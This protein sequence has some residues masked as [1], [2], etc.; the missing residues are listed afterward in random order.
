VND[1]PVVAN[2]LADL[3]GDEYDGPFTVDVSSVFTDKD[4]D[5][6][7]MTGT[8]SDTTVVRVSVTGT[9]LTISE[10][11]PG[12]AEITVTATDPGALFA[13][14]RFV[15]TLVN[16]NDAPEAV[17]PVGFL[18]LKEYFE[19]V[20][21]DI[22][23]V[24]FDKDGDKMTYSAMSSNTKVLTVS[25][26]GEK[27]ILNE[28]GLGTSTITL[29][30]SDGSL[31]GDDI[32]EVSVDNVNDNPLVRKL[33]PDQ[34]QY[35]Y[36][37]S[38]VVDLH[39]VFSDPDVGDILTLSVYSSDTSVVK[40]EIVD[41]TVVIT[42][43][44]LGTSAITVTVEDEGGLSASVAFGFTVWNVNDAPVLVEAVPDFELV[45]NIGTI[46][47]GLDTL[48]RDKDRDTLTYSI[49][50]SNPDLVGVTMTDSVLTFDALDVGV[51]QVILTA[52]DTALSAVDTF[53]ITVVEEVLLLLRY[54]GRRIQNK[55]TIDVCN[56]AGAVFVEVISSVEWGVEKVSEATWLVLGI[57]QDSSLNLAFS[58]NLLE[59]PRVAE[60]LVYDE[61][62]HQFTFYLEQSDCTIDVEGYGA[63]VGM[64]M[65]PNPVEH[66]L[67]ISPAEG[68]LNGDVSLEILDGNGRLLL[69]QE[70]GAGTG[71][72][73]V[74]M[75]GYSEGMYFV[76][77]RSGE[78][79]WMEK[80]IKL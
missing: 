6:L 9:T 29:T 20:D 63:R 64:R 57:D 69:Q 15:F 39:G 72:V 37:E 22:S 34:E 79:T 14:D 18:S 53:N 10:V 7:I 55:D 33:I 23:D 35:E 11:A 16:V 45:N 38:L 68:L 78:G 70:V 40:A 50:V 66:V 27:L 30:A 74:D 5:P 58:Q 26:E 36:F 42:E 41:T 80:V 31:S 12:S 44:G 4:G 47:F 54:D 71:T 19:T 28:A 43:T 76:R 3:S 51:V 67:Y 21:I 1:A 59:E 13:Q 48:F 73:A 46:S 49:V 52:S 56:P 25:V 60:I 62:G 75:S 61:Q 24:F 32:F 17:N 77:I 2:P 65:Y 8:S